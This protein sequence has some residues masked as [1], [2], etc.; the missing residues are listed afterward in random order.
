MSCTCSTTPCRCSSVCDATN[1]PLSSA[2]FNL[3]TAVL[4][5]VTKSCVNNQVV[6]VLPCDLDAGVAGYPRLANEG[7]VC[8]LLRIVPLI[9]AANSCCEGLKGYTL[10]TLTNADVT[11]TS[12]VSTID[13]QFNGTLTGPVDINALLTNASSGDKFSLSIVNLGVTGVNSLTVQSNGVNLVVFNTP[14]T[15]SGFVEL[16][17]TGTAWVITKEYTDLV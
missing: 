13:Q 6:W 4:G 17:Y 5:T 1:E 14:G 16:T 9:V 11:L 3:Q 8:Y 12:D 10:T 7:V 2:L 15:L